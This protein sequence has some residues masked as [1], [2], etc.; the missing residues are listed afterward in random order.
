MRKLIEGIVEFRERQLPHYPD[1]GRRMLYLGITVVATI[2][3][4]YELYVQGAV[5]PKIIE[6]YHFS[7]TEFVVVAAVGALFGAFASLAGG[8]RTGGAA[9]TWWS[10]GCWPPAC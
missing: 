4:Y 3:L 8:W 6:Q 7:F 1:T 10:A 5:A 9:R 2:T